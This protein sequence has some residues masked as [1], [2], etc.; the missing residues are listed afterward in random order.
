MKSEVEVRCPVCGHPMRE[1]RWLSEGG[2]TIVYTCLKCGY[3]IKFCIF[4]EVKKEWI[5]KSWAEA[6]YAYRRYRSV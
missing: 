1:E 3:R 4:H 6:S 2:E 5:S